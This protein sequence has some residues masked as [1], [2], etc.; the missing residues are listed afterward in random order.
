MG[1]AD[2]ETLAGTGGSRAL[3]NDPHSLA[4]LGLLVNYMAST[5]TGSSDGHGWTPK[6]DPTTATTE[7]TLTLTNPQS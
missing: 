5:F 3:D 1:F 4:S 2:I 6:V 7:H